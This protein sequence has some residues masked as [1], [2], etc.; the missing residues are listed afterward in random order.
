MVTYSKFSER[1]HLTAP[2][3]VLIESKSTRFCE[4]GFRMPVMKAGMGV[5][6]AVSHSQ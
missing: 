4:L 6:A 1:V 3:R 2:L 5:K